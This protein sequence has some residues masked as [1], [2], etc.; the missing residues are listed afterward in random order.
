MQPPDASLGTTPDPPHTLCLH[1][2]KRC[3][4]R[5]GRLAS[6]A[7]T[8]GR[9][10][11]GPACLHAAPFHSASPS[12]CCGGDGTSRS[13]FRPPGGRLQQVCLFIDLRNP[14]AI[15]GKPLRKGAGHFAQG[16]VLAAVL[17][18]VLTVILPTPPSSAWCRRTVDFITKLYTAQLSG[19]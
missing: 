2:L 10:C 11:R 16:L 7:A 18:A 5:T 17:A 4:L 9:A 8:S 15:M 12:S 3:P 19:S 14:D 1:E 13:S 6:L